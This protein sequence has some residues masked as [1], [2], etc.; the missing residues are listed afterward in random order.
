MPL[1]L[2]RVFPPE[3]LARH[4]AGAIMKCHPVDSLMEEINLEAKQQ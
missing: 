1:G 2:S 4:K 3:T